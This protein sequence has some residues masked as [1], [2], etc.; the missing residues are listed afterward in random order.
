MSKNP[1]VALRAP[2]LCAV[3]AWTQP[4][5]RKNLKVSVLG[6]PDSAN[7]GSPS[8]LPPGGR[9]SHDGWRDNLA[10]RMET[11]TCNLCGSDQLRPVYRQPDALFFPDRWFTVVACE[12]CGL[13]FVNPRPTRSEMAEYYPAAFFGAFEHPAHESRYAV[14]ASFLP[15]IAPGAT[16]RLLDIG[17]ANGDFPRYMRSR[18]WTVEG[19]EVSGNAAGI[20]DFPVY[21]TEFPEVPVEDATYDAITAWAVLEHTHDPRAYFAA[22]ARLLKPGGR[23]VFLVTNFTSLSS[24]ALFREDLPRHLYF[25]TPQ[26]LERYLAE[27]GLRC[28]SVKSNGAI[29]AMVPANILYYAV[30]R[31]L[32]RRPL[33]WEDLPEPRHQY[34]K[35]LSGTGGFLIQGSLAFNIRYAL[36]HPLAVL[37]RV[38]A[39]LFE[40][41]QLLTDRYG[42][43][44][45]VAEKPR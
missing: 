42:I 9:S 13:G 18:G 24:R 29:F 2:A 31:Y 33:R 8:H 37:D 20:H 16:P 43:L 40:R 28:L 38:A 21:R 23:F 35:R 17:C 39:K 3:A 11:V 5:G 27:S 32:L 19:V 45:C 44:V 10:I 15:P 6:H 7:V 36:S 14:E 22:A 30:C 1:A 34:L 12:G 4:V 26:T 41:W 25:F